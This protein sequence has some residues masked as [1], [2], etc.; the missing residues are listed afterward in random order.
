MRYDNMVKFE[1]GVK[2]LDI[3]FRHEEKI[4]LSPADLPVLRQRL[5]AVMRPDAHTPDGRYHIR[6]LYFDTP[7]DRALREK[8]DGIS[9]REK[10]RIRCYNGDFSLIRLEKKCKMAGIGW[11][12]QTCLSLAD[13]RALLEGR[14]LSVDDGQDALLREFCSRMRTQRLQPKTIVDY[15]REAFVYAPGNVR[16]TLDYDI[17]RG[18]RCADFLNPES[19][20][21][22]VPDA[23]M[24]MEVKWDAFLPDIIRDAVQ[25]PGRQSGAF[26]KYASCRRYD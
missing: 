19:L 26:S 4:E 12:E 9:R 21:I 3:P 17:R 5:R 14:V 7:E 22:P 18:L 15:T 11:K 25:L 6:S 16:V 8:L 2:K 10:F 24:L 20:S 13:T 23:P 1:K